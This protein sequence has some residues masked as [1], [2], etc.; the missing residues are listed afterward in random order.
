MFGLNRFNPT[1][2][3][4]NINPDRCQAKLRQ[5]AGMPTFCKS[6]LFKRFMA[7]LI[8]FFVLAGLSRSE[9]E[10]ALHKPFKNDHRKIIVVDPGHG[11]YDIGAKGPDGSLEKTVNLT[12]ARMISSEL[13]EKY[14]I[15][16]TRTDDYFIDLIDRTSLA[17]QLK[18]DVFVSIHTGASLLHKMS[19]TS[20]FYY[21]G[22]SDRPLDTEVPLYPSSEN[23]PDKTPWHEI[24]FKHVNASKVLAE[25][26]QK[27]LERF[28][29]G[30]ESN[31]QGAPLVVLSGADMPSILMEIGY[32]TNP[33]DEKSLQDKT[34]LSRVAKG[35]SLGLDAFL[36]QKNIDTL[37]DLRE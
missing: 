16:L 8:A 34:F 18:A 5:G 6:H 23:G 12:I 32:L 31:I 14:R 27:G 29:K 26:T 11:G 30:F 7:L 20:L 4:N 33:A 3:K 25:L 21:Q 1:N 36:Q 2:K 37:N 10:D 22:I 19:G 35:I 15:V 9:D 24:Q 13:G 28:I 17:N